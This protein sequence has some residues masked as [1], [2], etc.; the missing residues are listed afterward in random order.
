MSNRS[1]RKSRHQSKIDLRSLICE[2]KIITHILT[3]EKLNKPKINDYS[4][5]H[6]RRKVTSLTTMSKSGQ[7]LLRTEW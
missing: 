6:Q 2:K 1:Y 7:G 4:Q 3:I 5:T